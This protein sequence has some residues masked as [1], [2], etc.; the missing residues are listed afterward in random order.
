M[1]DGGSAGVEQGRQKGV[2]HGQS[3]RF[4]APSPT[5]DRLSTPLTLPSLPVPPFPTLIEAKETGDLV[6]RFVAFLKRQRRETPAERLRRRLRDSMTVI[7]TTLVPSAGGEAAPS[8]GKFQRPRGL[9]HPYQIKTVMDI[10]PE[11]PDSYAGERKYLEE[12]VF[13]IVKQYKE[14]IAARHVWTFSLHAEAQQYFQL[15][16]RMRRQLKRPEPRNDVKAICQAVYDNYFHGI[17][18]YMMA[19]YIREQQDKANTI[20]FDFCEAFR[21]IAQLD[22]DGRLLDQP[23]RRRL[24]SRGQLLYFAFR[25]EMVLKQFNAHYDYSRHFKDTLKGFPIESV[26]QEAE[27]RDRAGRL[28]IRR[29]ALGGAA[30]AG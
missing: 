18:Y 15:A 19:I 25:D 13:A 14:K 10:I 24:P 6:G 22:W 17:Y 27:D 3:F 7:R 12:L 11:L 26:H 21:F 8:K 2:I 30:P 20:F 28:R 23:S 9:E 1:S 29:P 4:G 5:I 16:E